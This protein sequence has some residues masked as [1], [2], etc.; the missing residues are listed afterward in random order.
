[1]IGVIEWHPLAVHFPLALGVTGAL[2]LSAARLKG[3]GRHGPTLATIGTWNICLGALG[4]L[5][6]V[7]TGLAAV[8]S[9]DLEPAARLA[10]G[11][12]VKWAI[13]ATVGLLLI[14]AWRGAGNDPDSRPSRL[15]LAVMWAVIAALIVTGYRGGQNV[16]RFGVGV[17]PRIVSSEPSAR[18]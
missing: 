1:M 6:A 16:Y 10:V 4:A 5:V 12:H 3:V 2:A 15:F 11:L 7:A 9:L 13:F 18:E 8:A 14:A 17:A